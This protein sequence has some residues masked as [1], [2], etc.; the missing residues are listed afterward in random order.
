MKKK[1]EWVLVSKEEYF[2]AQIIKGRLE[3]EDIPV[4]IEKE[5]V[6]LLYGITLDGLGGVR[7]YVPVQ[8]KKKAEE[9]L[10]SIK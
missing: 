3:S 4:K 5:T 6:G 2:K 8:L 7:I 1:R 10:G 9:I